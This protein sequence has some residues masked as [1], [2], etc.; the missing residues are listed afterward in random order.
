MVVL[1]TFT[2]IFN[3]YYLLSG[4]AAIELSLL[5]NFFW[6]DRWTFSNNDHAKSFTSRLGNYHVISLSGAVLNIMFLYV[7][8]SI[9]GFYYLLSNIMAICCVF[10]LN[11]F[12]NTHITW[13][14][15]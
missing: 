1:Y 2:D 5:N 9:L 12:V 14:E 8:T 11:Y 15:K 7:F 3:I 10:I 13:K 4:I 6:N